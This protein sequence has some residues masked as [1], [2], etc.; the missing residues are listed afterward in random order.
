MDNR[1][2]EEDSED[3]DI[4]EKVDYENL[5]VHNVLW[6]K[7]QDSLE[8]DPRGAT[9]KS[10]PGLN[11]PNVDYLTPFGIFKIFSDLL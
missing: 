6:S 1:E 4:G 2:D 3:E 10:L 7:W 11:S 8:F 5:T 9:K